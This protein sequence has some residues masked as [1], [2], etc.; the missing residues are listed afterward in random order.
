MQF[1]LVFAAII[2]RIW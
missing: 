2:S 1:C